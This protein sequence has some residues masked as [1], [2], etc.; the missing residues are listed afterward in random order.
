MNIKALMIDVDGV[1]VIHPDPH[2][3]S[4]DLERDLGLSRDTLQSEIFQAALRRNYSWTRSS[5]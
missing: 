1:I 5:S 2:G 4:A 3:W